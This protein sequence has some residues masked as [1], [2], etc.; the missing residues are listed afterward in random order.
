MKRLLYAE[1][2][3]AGDEIQL[4]SRTLSEDE[5]IAYA[6]QW[7]PL[8]IHTDREHAAAGPFGRI[9]ASGLHTLGV[10][11]AL[12]VGSWGSRVANK[13]GKQLTIKFLR[14]VP[15]G[16]TL[17]GRTRLLTVTL[18][19]ERRDGLVT[20]RSELL[21]QDGHVVLEVLAEGVILMSP[22]T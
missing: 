14:P 17:T 7:D 21:D 1:D 12:M 6:E 8:P 2:L 22:S 9:I 20:M 19:P 15:G 4:G 3:Q 5:I 16:T 11:Q 10:Y 13:A 18:R